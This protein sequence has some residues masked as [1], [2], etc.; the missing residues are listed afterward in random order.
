MTDSHD[1]SPIPE[2]PMRIR[3][4]AEA[5]AFARCEGPEYDLAESAALGQGLAATELAAIRRVAAGLPAPA[6]ANCG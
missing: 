6:T 3:T 5:A 4:P 1:T 2:I